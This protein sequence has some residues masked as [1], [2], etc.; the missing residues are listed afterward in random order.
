MTTERARRLRREATAGERRLWA[1]LRDRRLQGLKFRRQFPVGP[2]VLDFV[3]LRHRL[4]LEADGPLHDPERDARRDA[5]LAARGF[6]VIR[7]ANA[8][9]T[10]DRVHAA[11][12]AAIEPGPG[13]EV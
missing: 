13:G 10:R 4:A 11:V 2:Y 12:I 7:F 3:C 1:L 9:I 6:R 8:E 5:W